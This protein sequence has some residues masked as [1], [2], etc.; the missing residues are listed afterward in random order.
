MRV[1]QWEKGSFPNQRV[2]I[3]PVFCYHC[4]I[5]VC[6]D[7]CPDGEMIKEEKYGAV[8]I[9]PE[10]ATSPNLRKAWAVCPYGAIVFDSD[11]PDAKASMCN[12]CID[13]LEDGKIPV[14][15]E[16]CPQRALDFGTL[17]D[18]QAKYGN[19]RDLEDFPSSATA[20]P[21]IVFKAM[22]P[23]KEIVPYN[24]EKGMSLLREREG[25]PATYGSKEDVVDVPPGTVGRGVL[26]LH[27]K[28]V[29]ELIYQTVDDTA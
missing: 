11:A 21:A 24:A 15:V 27:A 17:S 14:C 28:S 2:H 1:H 9:D 22:N 19:N 8:L 13:R 25:L 26:N 5:P 3:A 20:E 10:K 16:A 23:R 29:K 4:E 18:M 12:M 7:A 6:I